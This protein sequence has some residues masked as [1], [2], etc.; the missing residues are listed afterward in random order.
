MHKSLKVFLV[1]VSRMKN[2]T[3]FFQFTSEKL[4][5]SRSVSQVAD[6]LM[7]LQGIRY[8]IMQLAWLITDILMLVLSSKPNVIAVR[9]QLKASMH[10]TP[11]L[12]GAI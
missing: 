1:L 5:A 7:K 2:Q 11:G 3:A 10:C 6:H 8:L 12:I 4:I 9:N